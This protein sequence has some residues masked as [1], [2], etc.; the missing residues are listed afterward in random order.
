MTKK[1]AKKALTKKKAVKK[2]KRKRSLPSAKAWTLSVY[3]E[4]KLKKGEKHKLRKTFDAWAILR[5]DG[6]YNP[7]TAT[8]RNNLWHGHKGKRVRVKFVVVE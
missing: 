4:K 7:L 6:T 1:K 8:A 5:S 3:Y 2:G